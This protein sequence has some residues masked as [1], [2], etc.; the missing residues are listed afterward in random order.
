M[1]ISSNGTSDMFPLSVFSLEEW[2]QY[3]QQK[4]GV[5]PNPDW[6]TTLFGGDL[7]PS[8]VTNLVGSNIVFRFFEFM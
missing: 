5:T 2:T 7:L 3:C 1:P 6:V 4:W 8:G